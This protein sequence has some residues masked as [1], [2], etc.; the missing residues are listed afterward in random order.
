MLTIHDGQCGICIHFGETKQDDQ[1]K[2][3]QIR[4][5]RQAP[6]DLVEPCGHPKNR[7]VELKVSPISSCE[8][9]EPASANGH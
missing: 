5:S 7:N 6:V 9:F 2:L 8:G 1:P 4:T 3:V